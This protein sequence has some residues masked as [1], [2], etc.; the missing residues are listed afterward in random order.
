MRLVIL[1]GTGSGKATQTAKISNNFD[2]LSVSTG[3]ILR[4]GIA[5]ESNLGLTR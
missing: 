2:I 3:E 1:G 4:K 5:T